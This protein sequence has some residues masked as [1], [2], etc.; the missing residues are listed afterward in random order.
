MTDKT[1]NAE[2]DHNVDKGSKV[3]NRFI[4]AHIIYE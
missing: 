2:F 1:E 4:L 3:T